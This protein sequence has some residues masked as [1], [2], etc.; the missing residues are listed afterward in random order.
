VATLENMRTGGVDTFVEVGPGHTLTG[1]VKRTLTD[2]TAL[3]CETVEQLGD[4]L[5]V[6]KKGKED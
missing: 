3:S 2:V 6:L 5:A 1:L 4:V